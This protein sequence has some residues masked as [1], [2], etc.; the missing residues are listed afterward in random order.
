MYGICLNNPISLFT[1]VIS[2][3]LLAPEEKQKVE[4]YNYGSTV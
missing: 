4:E 3:A 1:T 2:A